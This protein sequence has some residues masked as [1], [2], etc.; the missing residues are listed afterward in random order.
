M[1]IWANM[2]AV[3]LG[4][5]GPADPELLT[6]VV[7]TTDSLST[8]TLSSSSTSTMFTNLSLPETPSILSQVLTNPTRR[9][10]HSLQ[11][12]SVCPPSEPLLSGLGEESQGGYNVPGEENQQYRGASPS[13]THM[14]T[15]Y[16]DQFSPS[17]RVFG[18][19]LEVEDYV[20]QEMNSAQYNPNAMD[21]TPMAHSEEFIDLDEFANKVANEVANKAEHQFPPPEASANLPSINTLQQRMSPPASPEHEELT[22]GVRVSG[23]ITPLT[24]HARTRQTLHT[25]VKV[26]TPPSSPNFPSS[27][28]SKQISQESS[29][30]SPPGDTE[31]KVTKKPTGRKKITAH[32]CQHPGCHKTYTKSSHLKAHLRTHTGEK[33]YMCGW[34]GCGWKF[35]RSDEL[36]RH[37]RKHTGDRPFQC[38]L[39][40]R[41]FSRSDHLSL[42]MKRHVSV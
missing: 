17:F 38:R 32:T 27:E 14:D 2:D 1:L 37:H 18:E 29:T 19:G 31:R 41:A 30:P 40:E 13:S 22:P 33:P 34:K 15:S 20:A 21:E 42:H 5:T 9:R 7:D 24:T 3:L 16:H 10:P 36:T 25:Q 39:C 12:T 6:P 35:A 26:M 4:E 23:C 28:L 11:Y 8:P